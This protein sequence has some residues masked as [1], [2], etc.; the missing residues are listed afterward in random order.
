[1]LYTHNCRTPD[2]WLVADGADSIPRIEG[3]GAHG[4]LNV[5]AYTAGSGII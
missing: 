1:M 2:L 5:L 3:L 4:K